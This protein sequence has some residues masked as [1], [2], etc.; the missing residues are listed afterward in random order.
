MISLTLLEDDKCIYSLKSFVD[1]NISAEYRYNKKISALF[2]SIILQPKNTNIG[3]IF[4]F[5]LSIF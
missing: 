3:L 2:S 4:Q 5:N 1:M